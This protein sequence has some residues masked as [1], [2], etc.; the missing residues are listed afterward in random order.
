MKR[1]F[2][3]SLLFF[4]FCFTQLTY[5]APRKDL[6]IRWQVNNPLSK[7]KITYPEWASFLKKYVFTNKDNINL[8]AYS[9]VTEADK[10]MLHRFLRRMAHI[11]INL[12]NRRQQEA[13]WINVYNALTVDVVLRHYPVNSIRKI[14]ISGLFS[15]GPWGAKLIKVEGVSITLNDIEHRILRPIW[16]DQRIHYALNCASMSCPNLQKVPFTPTN[17]ETLLNKGAHAYVNSPRGTDLQDGKLTVSSIYYWYKADFG[18]TDDDVI[19]WME[20]FA[21]P[22]LRTQLK[23]VKMIRNQ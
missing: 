9:R 23:F 15:A 10:R 22:V 17:L 8:V 6:W 20:I 14:R 18:G 12:Y 16:N 11:R 4:L 3:A 19:D 13:Y 7:R 1:I 5:A 2:A 21:N